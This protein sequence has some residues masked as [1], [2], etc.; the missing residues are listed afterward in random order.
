M[1]SQDLT[2]LSKISALPTPEA[3]YKISQSLAMLD[4]ILDQQGKFRYFTFDQY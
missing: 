4:A 1:T 2:V 3:I